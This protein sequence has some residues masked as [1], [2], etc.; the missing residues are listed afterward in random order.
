VALEVDPE[1]NQQQLRGRLF[2]INML[3][4][5]ADVN[6]EGRFKPEHIH[7][8][9]VKAHMDPVQ[10]FF[11]DSHRSEPFSTTPTGAN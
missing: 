8:C 5:D 1:A 11:N 6:A 9:H 2:L 4:S 10:A 7:L 3:Y